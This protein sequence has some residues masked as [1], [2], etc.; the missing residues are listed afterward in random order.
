V[1]RRLQLPIPRRLGRL[2]SLHEPYGAADRVLGDALVLDR[3]NRG[4]DFRS[5]RADTSP[6][7][8]ECSSHGER[9]S[10]SSEVRLASRFSDHVRLSHKR[11]C[12]WA[13]I[14]ATAMALGTGCLRLVTRSWSALFGARSQLPT[15]DLARSG[16]SRMTRRPSAS[17]MRRRSMVSSSSPADASQRQ[18]SCARTWT[19]MGSSGGATSI[20]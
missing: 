5:A 17:V 8:Q 19:G 10:H 13:G 14:A 16:R 11:C 4:A 18:V 3:R 6:E 20:R 7:R 9:H 2:D 15:G 1:S 12:G